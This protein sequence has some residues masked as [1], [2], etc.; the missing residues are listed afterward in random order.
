MPATIPEEDVIDKVLAGERISRGE[1][2][3]L[4]RLPLNE[5]GELAN[6][7][8]NLAGREKHGGRGEEIVTYI[9]DRNINYIMSATFTASSARFT[10]RRRTRITTS[11]RARNWTGSWTN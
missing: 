10:A 9:V 8:R 4:Y 5:L 2:L 7:R 6:H 3:E 11:S 1:A